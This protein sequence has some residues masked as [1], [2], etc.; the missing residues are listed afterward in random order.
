MPRYT[1]A[2]VLGSLLAF[3][4]NELPEQFWSAFAP[5]FLLLGFYCRRYRFVLWFVAAYLWSSAALHYHLEHRL[6]SDYDQQV[7]RLR[8]LV[9]DIPE[10]DRG[11]IRFYLR[12]QEIS[13]YSAPLPRLAKLSWYQD[14]IVPRSGE[15]WQF[16]VKLRQPRGMLNFAGF[17]F[18]ALQFS[19][20]IDATGYVRN[21]TMN[22]MLEPASLLNLHRAR[23]NIAQEIDRNCVDCEHRGLIKALSLEFR[24]DI[25]SDQRNLL[26]S[27]GAAHLLAIFGLQIGMLSL[28]VLRL[29]TILLAPG[30][31]WFWIK[32]GTTGFDLRDYRRSRLRGPGRFRAAH[33][34][35]SGDAVCISVR[36]AV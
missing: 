13:G 24:G 7:T 28:Y 30:F 4:G 1:V 33:G 34:A 12:V 22:R 14:E 21:S 10:V 27:T 6:V 32:T 8:G 23:N 3:Y 2:I 25:E 18:E 5:M 17:D 20:G 29:R 15:Y 11:Q 16:E 35:R 31:L 9:T 19:R 26:Q 36:V